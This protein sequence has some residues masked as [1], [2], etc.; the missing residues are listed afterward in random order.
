[1]VREIKLLDKKFQ[2]LIQGESR[3]F[4]E[5][6]NRR[7]IENKSVEFRVFLCLASIKS[8]ASEK[9]YPLCEFSELIRSGSKVVQL[10]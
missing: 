10:P 9:S 2:R 1:M 4:R 7:F 8:A 5:Y 3:G 6:D